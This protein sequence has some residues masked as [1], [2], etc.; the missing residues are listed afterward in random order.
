MPNVPPSGLC[1]T[2]RVEE[3]R[4]RNRRHAGSC[5][6]RKRQALDAAQDKNAELTW[7][8]EV[9]KQALHGACEALEYLKMGC[10]ERF[11]QAGERLVTSHATFVEEQL[12][13]DS[14]AT[15][16]R[17]KTQPGVKT[18]EP[19]GWATFNSST[20]TSSSGGGG[21][22]GC[23]SDSQKQVIARALTRVAV[24]SV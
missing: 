10:V 9:H 22:S 8:L 12:S 19:T 14:L 21:G 6:A 7:Q 1:E 4:S 5:R 23:G 16:L 17:A 11:G 20:T 13:R 15:A 3:L 2:E 18:A 24:A